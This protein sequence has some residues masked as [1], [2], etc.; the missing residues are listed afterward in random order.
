[1]VRQTKWQVAAR[2]VLSDPHAAL[3]SPLAL[4]QSSRYIRC[5]Y[6]WTGALCPIPW[7]FW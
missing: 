5:E 4:S 1:M 2:R 3:E 6:P 7:L